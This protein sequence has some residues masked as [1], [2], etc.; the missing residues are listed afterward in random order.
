MFESLFWCAAL[1]AL[2]GSA[3]LVAIGATI[4]P[5]IIRKDDPYPKGIDPRRI[6]GR[7]RRWR[8]GGP[9]VAPRVGSLPMR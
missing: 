4:Q 3:A 7:K 2:I 9:R 5:R 6:F 8:R 1:V